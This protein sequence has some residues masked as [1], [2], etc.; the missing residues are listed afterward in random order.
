MSDRLDELLDRMAFKDAIR[1]CCRE[2]I[3]EAEAVVVFERYRI[4]QDIVD[5]DD[6]PAVTMARLQWSGPPPSVLR[7]TARRHLLGAALGDVS[8]WRTWLAV[9]K[10]R[11]R[12]EALRQ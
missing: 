7:R 3:S 5:D 6:A 4:S 12:T 1:A 9:L 2:G 10:A 11:F 8:S